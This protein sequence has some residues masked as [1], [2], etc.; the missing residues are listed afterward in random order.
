MEKGSQKQRKLLRTFFICDRRK[1]DRKIRS[2]DCLRYHGKINRMKN[3][4]EGR[5]KTEREGFVILL[6]S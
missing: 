6:F 2:A 4:G 5:I 3:C 1:E